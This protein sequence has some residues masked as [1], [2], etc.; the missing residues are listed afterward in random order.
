MPLFSWFCENQQQ[1]HMTFTH[2]ERKRKLDIHNKTMWPVA[3]VDYIAS[4]NQERADV[5]DR[6]FE[7]QS[8]VN[9]SD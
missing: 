2:S 6:L 1:T 7:T 5:D 3:K 8:T 4:R 9:P